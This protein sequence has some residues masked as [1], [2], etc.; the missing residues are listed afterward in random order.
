VPHHSL[1]VYPPNGSSHGQDQPGS[2]RF[3]ELLRAEDHNSTVAGATVSNLRERARVTPQTFRAR[4]NGAG[5]PGDSRIIST[6][7]RKGFLHLRPR[8]L[9]V[10]EICGRFALQPTPRPRDDSFQCSCG[11][12]CADGDYALRNF[13]AHPILFLHGT[14]LLFSLMGVSFTVVLLADT[15]QRPMSLTGGKR[16]CGTERGTSESLAS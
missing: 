10:V 1:S 9:S 12:E 11:R 14:G 7:H 16:L 5:N 6:C 4:K 8:L 15:F 2:I 3:G 13:L